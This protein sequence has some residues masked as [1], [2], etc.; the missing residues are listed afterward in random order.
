M[1]SIMF[2]RSLYFEVF[3]DPCLLYFTSC[4]HNDLRSWAGG[5]GGVGDFMIVDEQIEGR[6]FNIRVGKSEI[7]RS[8]LI[9]FNVISHVV[10]KFMKYLSPSHPSVIVARS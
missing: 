7:P 5:G 9:M 1:I 6:G 8:S 3:L 2:G 4:Q 10:A